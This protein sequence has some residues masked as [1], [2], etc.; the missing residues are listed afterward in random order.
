MTYHKTL[1]KFKI[2][3]LLNKNELGWFY[4]K[5]KGL[6]YRCPA[7]LDREEHK[8]DSEIRRVKFLL[9]MFPEWENDLAHE[10]PFYIILTE[11][12]TDSDR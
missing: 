9:S 5:N 2:K 8:C 6:R 7:T 12:Q 3:I 4:W 1:S 11:S 10:W